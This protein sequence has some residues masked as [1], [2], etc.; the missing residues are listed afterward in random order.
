MPS[1]FARKLA[2]FVA[3]HAV[4]LTAL[5]ALQRPA[6]VLSPRTE[7]GFEGQ[8]GQKAFSLAS[9]QMSSCKSL[10]DGSRQIVDFEV[11]GDFIGIRNI[12]FRSSE[13]NFETITDSALSEVSVEDATGPAVRSR[14]S[15][16]ASA[17][18]TRHH[19]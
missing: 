15:A 8:Q 14:V 10:R 3:L 18:A 19:P 7:L 6:S 12:L 1:L 2:H 9:G 17:E 11:A 16:G 4:E 5:E 13:H